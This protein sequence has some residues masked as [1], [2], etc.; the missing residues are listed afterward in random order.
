MVQATTRSIE[1]PAREF[2]GP[3][4]A[5]GFWRT[6]VFSTDHKVIGIQYGLTALC[7]LLLGFF[8]IL[9]M[10]WQ[11]AHP[12][13]P[14]PLVGWFLEKV[15][16]SPA[17]RG[18]MSPDLYNMFGAMHGTIMVF[19]AIVPLAVGAFGN[20]L[21]P[22]M[23]GAND[24][25][26][27]RLNMISYQL[28]FL[29][30]VVML[31]SF[32]I[33]GGAAQAGWTSYS[34]LA[35]VIPTDGQTFWLI[36]MVLLITSS[37][38]GSINIIT[39]IV[40]LRAPGLTWMRLPFFVW[41]QLAA[42]FLL[43]LAFP[44]LEAAG[45]MQLMDKVAG[46]SFFLPTGLAVGGA[47]AQIS[48]GGSPLLWQ[49]LFWFLAH[50]EVYVLILPAMGIVAEVLANNI[51]KPL[52]GYRTM[53]YAVL[54]LSFLSFI[55]WAHHMYL[56]GMGT[57]ISTFFQTTTIIISIPSVILLTC[58]LM[59]LWGGSIRIHTPMLFALAFLPMFGIGG[60]TGLPLGFAAS[61]I[62]L[63]DTYYVIGHFHYVVAPGTIFALFAGIY[64]WFPKLTGRRMNEF[65]G[66]VHFWCSF[67]FMNAV[68]L[69]M[70]AQG[71]AGMLRRM[72]DGGLSYSARISPGVEGT[73]SDF[74]LGL[75]NYILWAA[76]G[77]G[78][79]QLPFIINLFWSIWRGERVQG[80]NPWQATTLEWQTPTPPP[81]GNFL[82]LP[83]VYRGPYEYGRLDEDG[84]YL[85]QDRPPVA[86]T[87]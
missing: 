20:Y 17:S 12:G 10:R 57:R 24:M 26:F 53:V 19:L 58:L 66:R 32:L 56:T 6:Y 14:I 4:H 40:Q 30:G 80:D 70:F 61:D 27:P 35:T 62:Q 52:W 16:G 25:A 9:A 49:H 72:A 64:H 86:H 51:R 38:L 23:I 74:I 31:A 54:T 87:R 77:L 2:H 45:I 75:N 67:L 82:R 55:V 50:P 36:G 39:T 29:G 22:L 11:I 43:L 5:T 28:Y 37:L 47:T 1:F 34:P 3:A 63:H 81:H 48:G 83:Q 13:E 8:L 71:F 73:L 60:L 33:P 79:A 76:V 21:V 15:L 85:P 41:A 44:P 78:L 46:T 7:F 42:S 18:I 84:D 65:W 59:S 69:P 68:F